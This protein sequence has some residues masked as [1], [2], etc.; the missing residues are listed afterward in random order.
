MTKSIEMSQKYKSFKLYL[1]KS[2]AEKVHSYA[3][4]NEMKI[5]GLLRLALKD[6]FESKEN[7][8]QKHKN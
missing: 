5:T 3:K 6:F 2:L 1:D 4:D 7:Q 8:Q